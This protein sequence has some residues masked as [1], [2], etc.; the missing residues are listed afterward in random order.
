MGNGMQADPRGARG[1]EPAGP[2]GPRRP[3]EH[4][5]RPKTAQ[6]RGVGGDRAR[7]RRPLQ[8]KP[9]AQ[10][11]QH[12][13]APVPRPSWHRSALGR[14]WWF[15]G[16]V[17]TG[18]LP[19]SPPSGGTEYSPATLPVHTSRSQKFL[20]GIPTASCSSV[21]CGVWL[22]VSGRSAQVH[23]PCQGLLGKELLRTA[24]LCRCFSGR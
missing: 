8:E 9:L 16:A 5:E 21:P 18:T 20:G 13:A 24:S 3:A 7:Q 6:A 12:R 17:P 4:E 14:R 1:V 19:A 11:E 2:G 15:P 22:P 10:C 23:S